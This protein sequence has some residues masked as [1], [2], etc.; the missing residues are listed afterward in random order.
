MLEDVDE[1]DDVN[2]LSMALACSSNSFKVFKI[3]QISHGQHQGLINSGATH[4]LRPRRP[5]ERDTTYKRVSV[6]FANGK[7]TS[8]QVTPG[9]IMVTDRHAVEPILPMGQLVQDLGCQV[10][11]APSKTWSTSSS[12]PRWMRTQP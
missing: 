12:K 4:P 9:G 7:T 1:V 10:K 3:N 5:G 11:W 8:L 2:D 6:T